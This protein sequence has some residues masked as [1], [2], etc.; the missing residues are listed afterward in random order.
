MGYSG[1]AM[2]RLKT[3]LIKGLTEREFLIHVGLTCKQT[4]GCYSV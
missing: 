2:K 4:I 3:G 1:K